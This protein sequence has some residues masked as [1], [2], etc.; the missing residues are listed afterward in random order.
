VIL[1]RERRAVGVLGAK[2]LAAKVKAAWGVELPVMPA[3]PGGDF[4]AVSS[5]RGGMGF[6]QYQGIRIG[7]MTPEGTYAREGEEG[8]EGIGNRELREKF[9]QHGAWTAVDLM[10]APV[11]VTRQRVYTL[12]GKLAAELMDERALLLVAPAL[13]RVTAIDEIMVAGL[14]GEDA[15]GALLE[16]RGEQG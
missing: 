2:G 12:M 14:R 3:G 13:G 10:A 6:V 5:E 9:S 7:V 15:L 8:A 4:C 16:L 11:G 1:Q